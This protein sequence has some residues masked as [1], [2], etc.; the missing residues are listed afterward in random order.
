ML[1]SLVS[2]VALAAAALTLGAPAA[3]SQTR[4]YDGYCYVRPDDMATNAATA[5]CLNGEYYA[6]TDSYRAA[7][8]A[9]DGYQVEYFTRRPSHDVY[10]EVYN[11]S[12][13]TENFDP[14][15]SNHFGAGDGGY[16]YN[17]DTGYH[18]DRDGG[19]RAY[20]PHYAQQPQPSD[21]DV[22]PGAVNGERVAG[23]RDDRGEWH[24]GQPTAFGWRDDSGRWHVGKLSAYGWQDDQGEWHAQVPDTA[25]SSDGGY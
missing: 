13:L 23:W 18:D 2:G 10:S 17:G 16:A 3:Q 22:Q 14:G 15:A 19:D 11:A 25:P 9:P 5:P 6:Y 12:T 7:P 8:R 24:V 21:Q 1:R 4:Q 20:D